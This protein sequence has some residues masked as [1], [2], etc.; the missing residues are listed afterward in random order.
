LPVRDTGGILRPRA[1]KRG[2]RAII[3]EGGPMDQKNEIVQPFFAQF[4]ESQEDPTEVLGRTLKF[5]SDKDEW[6]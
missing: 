2:P 5:P 4:L 1:P 6:D 3:A